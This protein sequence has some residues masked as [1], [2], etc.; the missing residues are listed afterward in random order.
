MHAL[1]GPCASRHAKRPTNACITRMQRDLL[2]HALRAKRPTNACITRKQALRHQFAYLAR[3][4]CKRPTSRSL[5]WSLLARYACKRP[6]Y[7]Y[8][9][10][11]LLATRE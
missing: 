6:T 3:Y 7:Y 11:S 10:R 8:P 9:S 1:V 5:S 2:T 4:A